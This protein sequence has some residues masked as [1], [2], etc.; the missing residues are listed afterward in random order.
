MT[1]SQIGIVVVVIFVISFLLIGFLDRP[2]LWDHFARTLVQSAI[3]VATVTG[4]LYIFEKQLAERDGQTLQQQKWV[5]SSF[6]RTNILQL[7]ARSKQA[8]LM[9]ARSSE[10]DPDKPC[11]LNPE[12]VVSVM[13]QD[14]DGIT[15]QSLTDLHF[16][17]PIDRREY[18]QMIRSAGPLIPDAFF[19]KLMEGV[20][21][22]AVGIELEHNL[23]KQAIDAYNGSKD[24]QASGL[25]PPRL[26]EYHYLKVEKLQLT[27]AE[28]VN[29]FVCYLADRV[30]E[31]RGQPFQTTEFGRLQSVPSCPPYSES[32][33]KAAELLKLPDKSRL[34]AEYQIDH[35]RPHMQ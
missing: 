26:L 22:Y 2:R 9:G 6:L 23:L 25:L 14:L 19:D 29:T 35:S 16:A 12:Q 13:R 28:I 3:A 15:E 34:P 24:K 27:E 17:L 7:V 31:L 1:Y 21:D 8:A 33:Q 32:F 20:D 18:W 4:A 30:N 11:K 10:C 5:A